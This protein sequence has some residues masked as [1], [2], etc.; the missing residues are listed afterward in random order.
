MAIQLGATIGA[1]VYQPSDAP[2]YFKANSA[3][4]GLA[5]FNVIIL[6]PSTWLFYRYINKRRAAVWDKMTEAEQREYLST[7]KDVGNRR[8][9]FRFIK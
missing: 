6:Y 4:I 7:T 9:D 8:L 5:V 2:R 1:N 3:L